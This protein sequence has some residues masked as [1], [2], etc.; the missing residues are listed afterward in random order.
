MGNHIQRKTNE[1]I[2]QAN[3]KDNRLY[4][5]RYI[6]RY[7]NN[8]NIVSNNSSINKNIKLETNN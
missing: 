6:C 5:F 1:Y 7:N 3:G 8:F 4:G 2:Y